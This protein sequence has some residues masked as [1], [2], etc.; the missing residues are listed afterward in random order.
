MTTHASDCSLHNEPA[1]RNGPCDCGADTK[2]S[3]PLAVVA[4]IL[5]A[6]IALCSIIMFN[7]SPAKADTGCFV[8][9]STGAN[10]SASRL[11]DGNTG[12]DVGTASPMISGEAG[13][14]LAVQGFSLGGLLR[15]DYT[16]ANIKVDAA[17]IKQHGR[18]MALATVGAPIN[19]STSVYALGGLSGTKFDFA[20]VQSKT[21]MNWVIGGGIST[22][23]FKTGLSLFAEYNAI[24][25]KDLH[26]DG[27]TFKSAEH[28]A[29]VGVRIGF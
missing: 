13:C 9:G 14:K 10:V 11:S 22:N 3:K 21:A 1:Y 5:L 6:I 28:I 7:T 27:V 20:D 19:D 16:N 18:W 4:G 17:S 8:G 12:F 23:L 25:P 24:L 26:V 2:F 29:R 15:Y